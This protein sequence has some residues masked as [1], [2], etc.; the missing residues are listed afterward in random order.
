[1]FN[2]QPHPWPAPKPAPTTV[3]LATVT[4]IRAQH[5]PARVDALIELAHDTALSTR[6]MTGHGFD[7]HPDSAAQLARLLPNLT[8]ADAHTH[9]ARL[10]HDCDQVRQHDPENDDARWYSA[11]GDY[12]DATDRLRATAVAAVHA[13]TTTGGAA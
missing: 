3:R 2:P 12:E 10:V 6:T 4:P 7:L 9:L 8:P 5:D 13:D 11:P 1:M